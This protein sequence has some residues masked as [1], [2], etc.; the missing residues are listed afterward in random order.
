M[1]LLILD[2]NEVDPFGIIRKQGMTI[3][4][5][6]ENILEITAGF[7]IGFLIK[8]GVPPRIWITLNDEGARRLIELVRVGCENS[9]FVF[10]KCQSETM[11]ELIS[12]VPDITVGANVQI[13]FELSGV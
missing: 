9:G 6:G 2:E 1:P 5:C 10:A 11:K 7:L 8:F 4:V 3:Q 13:G 12:S